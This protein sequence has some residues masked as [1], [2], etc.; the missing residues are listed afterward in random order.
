MCSSVAVYSDWSRAAPYEERE[1]DLQVVVLP[2]GDVSQ[3]ARIL[4]NY[5]NGK[6]SAERRLRESGH[7]LPFTIMRPSVIEGPYD[8]LAR[9]WYWVQRIV[10]GRPIAIPSSALFVQHV[11]V[12][13]V[14]DAFLAVCNLPAERATYNVVGDEAITLRNYLK[15]IGVKC[16]REVLSVEVGDKVDELSGFPFFFEYPLLASNTALRERCGFT[17]TPCAGWLAKTVQWCLDNVSMDSAGYSSRDVEVAL[18]NE[19][20]SPANGI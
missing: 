8:P 16:G 4:N 19:V 17:P 18:C 2:D 10:D 15:I 3:R 9:T 12:N 13:D 7:D 20:L 11:Y 1:V 6:R 14:A 5:A